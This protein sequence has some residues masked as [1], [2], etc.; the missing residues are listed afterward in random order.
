MTDFRTEQETFWAGEFG[1]QYINRNPTDFELAARFAMFARIIDRTK[2]VRS[3][4]ELGANIGNNL[5][6]LDQLLSG[7]ELAAVEINQDAVDVLRQWGRTEV[8]HHSILDFRTDRQYD[9][10]LICGV[11]IHMNP[12]VLPQVYDLLYQLSKRY[13]F[14]AEYYNPT[15]VEIPYRGH[16]GKLFKRDFAGEMLDRFSDLR[17]LDYGFVYHRDNNFPLD[18]LNWF[19]LEKK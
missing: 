12:Q 15:P 6:V 2:G 4:I 8:Y 14:L 18:D 19:L 16:S 10:S 11:L 7:A 9:L 1:S 3:L 17:L 5:R 13:I